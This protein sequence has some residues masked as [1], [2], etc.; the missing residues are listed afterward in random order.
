MRTRYESRI[1]LSAIKTKDEAAHTRSCRERD[2]LNWS[3]D[4]ATSRA[5]ITIPK[6]G[7]FPGRMM[8]ASN[9]VRAPK[10]AKVRGNRPSFTRPAEVG[11]RRC[12]SLG[13]RPALP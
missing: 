8:A 1:R 9:A 3:T 2:G 4:A 11:R 5:M 13:E 10:R 12:D 6:P 7:P